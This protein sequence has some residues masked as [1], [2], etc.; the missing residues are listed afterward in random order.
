M[1]TLLDLVNL[2]KTG[3]KQVTGN[4]FYLTQSRYF[5]HIS[6]Y[7]APKSHIQMHLMLL[8]YFFTFSKIFPDRGASGGVPDGRAARADGAAAQRLHRPRRHQAGQLPRQTHAGIQV[9]AE[10]IF[11][12]LKYFLHCLSGLS[13]ACS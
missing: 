13:R 7:F 5:L 8:K 4:I 2:T 11:K 12:L 1:G 6:E 9:S 10:N 3:D